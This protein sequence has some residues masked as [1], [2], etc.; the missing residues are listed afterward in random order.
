M[1]D[2]SSPTGT[3][4]FSL[5]A[6]GPSKLRQHLWDEVSFG[7]PIDESPAFMSRACYRLLFARYGSGTIAP[8]G[9]VS[10]DADLSTKLLCTPLGENMRI[11][12]VFWFPLTKLKSNPIL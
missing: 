2:P 8:M 3:K 12:M 5:Q 9:R 7:V 6:F 10:K 4:A 1:Y 11:Q